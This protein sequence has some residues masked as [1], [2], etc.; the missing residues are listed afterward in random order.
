MADGEHRR[1]LCGLD[2]LKFP[3]EKLSSLSDAQIQQK[4]MKVETASGIAIL[5]RCTP[6]GGCLQDDSFSPLLWPASF[7]QAQTGRVTVGDR[8]ISLQAVRECQHPAFFYFNLKTK[9]RNTHTN[10]LD[11]H[12]GAICLNLKLHHFSGGCDVYTQ[13]Y[14]GVSWFYSTYSAWCCW[15]FFWATS[16]S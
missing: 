9:N 4:T 14:S 8:A 5:Q 15:M 16:I 7:Y 6:S 11:R 10:K 1:R 3:R 13:S 12:K 2:G